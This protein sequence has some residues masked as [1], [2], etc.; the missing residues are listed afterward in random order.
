MLTTTHLWPV[1][2]LSDLKSQAGDCQN[3]QRLQL[4][5]S[6]SLK[7][8]VVLTPTHLVIVMEYVA[9][10]DLFERIFNAGRF[11]EDEIDVV[12]L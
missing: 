4:S 10:G 1:L 12:C 3:D 7:S 8:Q 11:S 6:L 5:L 9:G 2:A